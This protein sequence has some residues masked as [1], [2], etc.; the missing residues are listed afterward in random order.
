LA[1]LISDIVAF[2]AM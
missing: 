1:G 2:L